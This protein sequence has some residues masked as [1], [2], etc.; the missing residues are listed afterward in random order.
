[1]KEAARLLVV[2]DDRGLRA[3]YT[4]MLT[5]AGGFDVEAAGSVAAARAW[6]A[7]HRPAAVVSDHNLPDGNGL[8]LLADLRP[9][10]GPA[11]TAFVL[12]TASPDPTVYATA[13][14]LDADGVLW[15]PV[16]AEVLVACVRAVTERR[17]ASWETMRRRES[18]EGSVESLVDL[19]IRTLDGTAPE[20]AERGRE[21]ADAVAQLG[22]E[23]DLTP[24]H[25]RTLEV[26]AR[27][28]EIALVL[29]AHAG[30][31]PPDGSA[32]SGVVTTASAAILRSVEGLQE[33]ADLIEGIGAAWDGTG[34]PAGMQRGM[35]PLRSRL[36]RVM[37]D[38]LTWLR[39]NA[40]GGGR[41]AQAGA[42]KA[43]QQR[44]GTWYDP[45][46]VA[47]L[48][49]MLAQQQGGAAAPGAS[50]R[51][52]VEALRSGMVLAA[53]LYTASGVM[54][55]AR[56]TMLLPGTIE[57]VRRRHEIDPVVRGV[58]VRGG[59]DASPI[60]TIDLERLG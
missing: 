8:E 38:F 36:L 24:E 59:L 15:K 2:E 7:L 58:S 46:V 19:L 28:H 23:F 54:L 33:T 37:L 42:L 50:N 57:L 55:L 29:G 48:S 43:I 26:A 12:V 3:L 1:M 6:L 13:W 60:A 18:A 34:H 25:A 39:H 52:P 40:H 30:V 4:S 21:L 56:G 53:D 51:I 49:T 27:L 22:V 31:E 9:V 16:D 35:I 20:L 10:D 14:R 44:S 5:A 17:M 41:D 47:A 11:A 45:A 32:P